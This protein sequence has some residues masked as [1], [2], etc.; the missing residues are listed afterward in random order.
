MN[1]MEHHN[2]IT[3]QGVPRAGGDEPKC[4]PLRPIEV[5]AECSPRGRG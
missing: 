4:D 5:I 1:R 3:R 2:I